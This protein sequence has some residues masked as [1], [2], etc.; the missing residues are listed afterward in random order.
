MTVSRDATSLRYVPANGSEWA[1]LLSGTGI[2]NPAHLYLFQE[3]SGNPADSI[4][5]KALTASGTLAYQQAV[6]G[7]S[8]LAIKTTRNAAGKMVNNTF[9][10]VNA[11]DYTV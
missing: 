4:D 8:R 9:A 3:A 11:N 6:A 5:G 1:E 2:P 10:N 7:W